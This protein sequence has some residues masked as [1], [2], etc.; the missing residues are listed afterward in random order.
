MVDMTKKTKTALEQEE[1][2]PST[3]SIE[4]VTPETRKHLEEAAQLMSDAK[5]IFLQQGTILAKLQVVVP[6]QSRTQPDPRQKA[7][8]DKVVDSDV[9]R[10]AALLEVQK[11]AKQGEKKADE[12][13]SKITPR[14]KL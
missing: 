5:K 13:V 14:R 8:L 3:S 9:Q 2:V 6:T 12:A 4:G 10:N 11:L 1:V 7:G